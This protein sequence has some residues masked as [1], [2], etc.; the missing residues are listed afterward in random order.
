MMSGFNG[1]NGAEEMI[2]RILLGKTI[3]ANEMKL[4]AMAVPY[5]RQMGNLATSSF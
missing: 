4:S 2:L 1:Y 3:P 5:H